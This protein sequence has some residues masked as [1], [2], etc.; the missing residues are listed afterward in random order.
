MVDNADRSS[1]LVQPRDFIGVLSTPWP[2]HPVSIG[3]YAF[4]I[5]FPTT[6]SELGRLADPSL[7]VA[8]TIA[9]FSVGVVAALLMLVRLLVPERLRSTPARGI[10]LLL[11]IGFARGA[12]VSI[13]VDSVGGQEESFALSRSVFGALSLPIVLGLVSLVVSRV[14]TSREIRTFVIGETQ[15]AEKSRDRVL[16]GIIAAQKRLLD[17][18]DQK[19]RPAIEGSIRAVTEAVTGRIVL[20]DALDLLAGQVIRPLSHDLSAQGVAPSSYRGSLDRRLTMPQERP[21]ASEQ[22][23]ASYS[24]LGVFLGSG[25]VLID[26]LPFEI[27]FVCGLVSGLCVFG[28]VRLTIA[29]VGNRILPTPL[30]VFVVTSVHS[31]A[32]IPPHLINQSL[33][34]PDGF[35]FQPWL[36]SIIGTAVLGLLYQVFILGSYSSREQLVALE[37]ARVNMAIDLS[38]A[39]R[40]AWLQQRHL[41]HSLHSAA[42]SRVNA[43]AR[44]IRTGA[45]KISTAEKKQTVVVLESVLDMISAETAP[46]IDAIRGISDVAEFW[47]GMCDISLDVDAGIEAELTNDPDVAEA[48]Q[49]VVLEM[50]SNAV[51][52]GRAT[53]IAIDVR[54]NTPEAILV[55]VENNGAP[56]DIGRTP[57]MGMALYDEL[58][59]LWEVATREDGQVVVTASIAARVEPSGTHAI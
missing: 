30:A 28:L 38:E 42:Q 43:Q 22:M 52:H 27:A 35:V 19:L 51:R 8:S 9:V 46:S 39:R 50:V 24:G 13:F 58:T 18:V 40:R 49:T 1:N 6:A 21:R 48:L 20:A 10:A 4:I 16:K 45:G 31:V 36:T 26:I 56:F 15:A 53:T 41:T 59:A 57:G 14:V 2:Y 25:T 34:F 44:L 17:E 33:L 55:T 7:G 23:S 12:I 29:M 47:S 11:T 32:W 5:T 54:R 37:T 3:L